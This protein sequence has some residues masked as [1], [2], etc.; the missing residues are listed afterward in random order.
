MKRILLAAFLI[1]A[2]GPALA[3]G[4]NAQLPS[5]GVVIH[6]FGP[7]GVWSNVLP[8]AP[9][10]SNAPAGAAPSA[11]SPA[12]TQAAAL[13][14]NDAASG[15]TA[16]I[17]AAT[18]APAAAYPEPTL[19]TVLHQMFITGDPDRGSGFSPGREKSY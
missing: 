7:D 18:P 16:P 12:N 17:G 1:L 15:V 8:T 10:P 4:R 13:S 14:S 19:G 5:S 9:A 2:A 3:S 11:A 6:L